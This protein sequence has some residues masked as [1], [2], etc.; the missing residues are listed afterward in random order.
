MPRTLVVAGL[1]CAIFALF[2]AYLTLSLVAL[3]MW[4]IALL[5]GAV[6]D[7]A[8]RINDTRKRLIA[9]AVRS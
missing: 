1:W 4:P 9:Q 5:C 6:L 8:D 2:L 7:V 3:I